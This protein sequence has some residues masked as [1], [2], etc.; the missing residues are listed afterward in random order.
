MVKIFIDPGHGGV[1]PGAS[2]NGLL[3]KDVTLKIAQAVRDNLQRYKG[4]TV[5]MS[6]TTDKTVS[7][8]ER[9]NLANQWGADFFLSIHI[10]AGKGTGFE[11]YIHSSLA[12]SSPTAKR[13]SSLHNAVLKT[14]R[15]QDRGKKSANFHVLRETKMSAVLTENGF[16]DTKA[17]ADLLKSQ[18]YLQQI[19]KGHA[20][21]IAT[22]YSLKKQATPPSNSGKGTFYRVVCG[23]YKEKSNAENRM[24]ELQQDGYKDVFIAPFE[25]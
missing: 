1:D 15:L 6:R 12:A 18:T 7:L 16:I 8:T 19:A 17:D 14:N 24:K 10:N 9:T 2:G 4:V 11:S 25:I 5:K 21:G 13:R 3:E 20:D 22:I 23:S